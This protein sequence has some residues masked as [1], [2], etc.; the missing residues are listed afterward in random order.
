MAV[1]FRVHAVWRSVSGW[2]IMGGLCEDTSSLLAWLVRASQPDGSATGQRWNL[3]EN[4]REF[5]NGCSQ[6]P[7]KARDWEG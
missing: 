4:L 6:D 7:S 3:S 1:R 5:L 2:Q